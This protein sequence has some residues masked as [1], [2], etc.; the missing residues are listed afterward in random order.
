MFRLTSKIDN[1]SD[2]FRTN[3]E[4]NLIL[5]E[6]YRNRLMSVMFRDS[7]TYVQRHI[8][9]GRLLARERIDL[10]ID[11]ADTRTV[12]GLSLAAVSGNE[13]SE[14]KPGIYRM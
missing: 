6:E 9:R 8:E 4:A 7:D 5:A 11:P 13:I 10:L 1:S 14:F 12:L 3:W 2:E